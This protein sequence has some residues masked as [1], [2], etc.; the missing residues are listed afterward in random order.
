MIA[1]LER[2]LSAVLLF[3]DAFINQAL[4]IHLPSLIAVSPGSKCELTLVFARDEN[5]IIARFGF[6]VRTVSSPAPERL[7]QSVALFAGLK[8]ASSAGEHRL[9]QSNWADHLRPSQRSH[10]FSIV[11]SGNT[12]KFPTVCT[13]SGFPTSNLPE[14]TNQKSDMI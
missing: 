12:L 6:F 13:K 14:P 3:R 11:S 9:Y 8:S 1:P 7:S 4:L 5:R 10:I 2:A